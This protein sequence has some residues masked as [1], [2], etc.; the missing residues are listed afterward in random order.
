[1]FTISADL[2]FEQQLGL[3]S[4]LKPKAG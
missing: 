1:M 4:P 3:A 2:Q